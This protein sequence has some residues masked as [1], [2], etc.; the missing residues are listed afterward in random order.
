[1]STASRDSP[2]RGCSRARGGVA[3][4]PLSQQREA[5]VVASFADGLTSLEANE[6]R[7]ALARLERERDAVLRDATRQRELAE[8]AAAQ[9]DA[10]MAQRRAADDE[11]SGLKERLAT[12]EA[13][14]DD[15]L[16][17]GRLQRQLM[18]TKMSYKVGGG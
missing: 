16:L 3:L 18:A 5:A 15:S 10:L 2:P 14:S 6:L 1:M 12:F 9:A 7:A 17:I 11:A 8:A 13:A 4:A